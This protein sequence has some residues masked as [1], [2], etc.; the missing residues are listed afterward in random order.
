MIDSQPV[1]R[2]RAWGSPVIGLPAGNAS[3]R[4]CPDARSLFEMWRGA[5][6]H[7]RLVEIYDAQFSWSREDDFFFALVNRTPSAKVADLGCGTGQLSETAAF[8]IPVD[9][10]RCHLP[11]LLAVG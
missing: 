9:A 3:R 10:H 6:R 8:P 2:V 1:M 4:P 11:P 5:F 7:P